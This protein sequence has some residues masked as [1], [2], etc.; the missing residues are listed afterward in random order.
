MLT[1]RCF[2]ILL[3]NLL[4]LTTGPLLVV[5]FLDFVGFSGLTKAIVAAFIIFITVALAIAGARVVSKDVDREG[6]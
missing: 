5:D 3:F 1:F 4:A 2:L 6:W